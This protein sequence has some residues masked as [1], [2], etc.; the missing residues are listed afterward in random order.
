MAS[1]QNSSLWQKH[2]VLE[3]NSILMVVG[4]IVMIAFGGLVEIVPL[5]YLKR[6]IESVRRSSLMLGRLSGVFASQG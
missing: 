5:F 1:G 3:R 6:T 4:I 2:G